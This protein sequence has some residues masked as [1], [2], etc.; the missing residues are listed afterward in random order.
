MSN[1]SYNRGN[2]VIRRSFDKKEEIRAG[3]MIDAMNADMARL[4]AENETLKKELERARS[5]C[6]RR[7]AET[8]VLKEEIAALQDSNKSSHNL[9]VSLFKALVDSRKGHE[10]LTAVMKIALTPEQYHQYREAAAEV[11]PELFRKGE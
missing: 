10:K 1:K 7:N 2:E 3:R 6:Q 11:Y 8:E 9:Y 5:A 4:Q